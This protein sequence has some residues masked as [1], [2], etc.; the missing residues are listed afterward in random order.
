MGMGGAPPQG[1]VAGFVVVVVE[2]VVLVDVVVTR[3]GCR[4]GL[5]ADGLDPPHAAPSSVTAT[6]TPAHPR[7]TVTSSKPRC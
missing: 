5:E 2:E 7:C 3:C 4:E 1:R 6:T